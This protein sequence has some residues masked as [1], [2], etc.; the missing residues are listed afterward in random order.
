[1]SGQNIAN[2]KEE[3]DYFYKLTRIPK[4]P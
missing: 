4:E 1:M 2:E 3:M